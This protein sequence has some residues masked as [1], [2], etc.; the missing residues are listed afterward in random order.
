MTIELYERAEDTVDMAV[1]YRALGDIFL[2][3]GERNAGCH[4]YRT[5]ILAL[6]PRY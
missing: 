2:A 5:Q 1:T 6:E 3:R 4:A